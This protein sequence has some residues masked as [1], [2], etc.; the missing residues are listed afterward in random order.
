MLTGS[1]LFDTDL[2][3]TKQANLS[4]D[5]FCVGPNCYVKLRFK[6]LDCCASSIHIDTKN[7]SIYPKPSTITL[8]IQK[9][10]IA[11]DYVIWNS[12]GKYRYCISPDKI[13][14]D[15][16][17]TNDTQ[18]GTNGKELASLNINNQVEANTPTTEVENISNLPSKQSP[19]SNEDTQPIDPQTD[20]SNENQIED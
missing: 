12:C 19:F 10:L 9:M 20:N 14:L 2:N 15:T 6:A 7:I 1:I 18:S 17:T 8:I 5:P 3:N 11:A 16:S 13:F 4:Q